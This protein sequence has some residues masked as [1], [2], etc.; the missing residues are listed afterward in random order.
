ME[1]T[2]ITQEKRKY[3]R[4]YLK[5]KQFCRAYYKNIKVIGNN[6]FFGEIIE[7]LKARNTKDVSDLNIYDTV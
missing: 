3:E 7:L 4:E 2:K 6:P 5:K 1:E